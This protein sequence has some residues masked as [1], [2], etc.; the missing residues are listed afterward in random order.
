MKYEVECTMSKNITVVVEANSQEEAE[1]SVSEA[2]DND[3]FKE[4]A[5]EYNKN[6]VTA[7]DADDNQV[8]QYTINADKELIPQ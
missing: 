6:D 7:F 3:F 2:A 1:N 5:W 8:V 4:D